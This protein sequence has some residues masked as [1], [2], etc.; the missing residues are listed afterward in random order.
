MKSLR[1]HRYLGNLLLTKK[2]R[3][4]LAWLDANRITPAKG[5]IK[6]SAVAEMRRDYRY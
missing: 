6:G 2:H 5:P 1:H 3:L 4:D